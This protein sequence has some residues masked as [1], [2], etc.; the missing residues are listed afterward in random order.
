MAELMQEFEN[1]KF[2]RVNRYSNSGHSGESIKTGFECKMIA[3]HCEYDENSGLW[4]N[5]NIDCAYDIEEYHN[6][7]EE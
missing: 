4:I 3:S 6:K 1:S 7:E 2:Y 5:H